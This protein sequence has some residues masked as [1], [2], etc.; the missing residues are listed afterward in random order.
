VTISDASITSGTVQLYGGGTLNGTA[1]VFNGG[2]YNV[3]YPIFTE[4]AAGWNNNRDLLLSYATPLG[5]NS[6]AGVSFVKSYYNTPYQHFCDYAGVYFDNS[7][8]P[9]AISQTTNE[10]RVFVGGNP[11]EKMSL[12]LSTY[13]VNANYHVGAATNTTT[14]SDV[15]YS[16]TAPRLGFVWRPTASVAVRAAAG[17]GFAEAPLGDL[18]GSNGMP[19]INSASSPAYYTV[20]SQNYSLQPEKSFAFDFGTDIRLHRDTIFSFDVYRSNVYGQV[21]LATLANGRYSGAYGTL[22]LYTAEYGNI[23][24]SRYEGVLVDLR[25]DT[26]H[27]IYWSFSGGLTRAY[28]V[29]IPAGFYDDP[30]QPCTMCANLYIVPGANFN[31]ELNSVGVAVPYAQ[32]LGKLG[33][34]WSPDKYVDMI[35]TYYGNNNTYFR[36]AFVILSGHIG[37]PVTKNISLLATFRNING[38]YDNPIQT[39]SLANLSGASSV[40]GLPYPLYGEEYGPRTVILTTVIH[41]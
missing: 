26:P 30:S 23:G 20:L 32:S 3:T 14:Y 13:F 15:R 37:Y 4:Y 38:V 16:Y 10:L 17:G 19:Q 12:D 31:G 27:G 2:T 9:S 18:I 5:E 41:L 36:P 24:T 40:S 35:G 11:S 7:A 22:P 25:H 28:V 8:T 29:S 6:H 21:Y 39:F 33:Y 1:T 34:R